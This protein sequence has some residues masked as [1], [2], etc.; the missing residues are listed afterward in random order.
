MIRP[1][2]CLAL[3]AFPLLPV[4]AAAQDRLP[5]ETRYTPEPFWY[6]GPGAAFAGPKGRMRIVT[7]GGISAA[8]NI[9]QYWT[10]E[11]AYRASMGRLAMRMPVEQ[12]DPLARK[13]AIAVVLARYPDRRV[14]GFLLEPIEEVGR[15]A[16]RTVVRPRS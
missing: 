7:G 13:E 14:N 9:N 4:S 16:P 15:S 6:Q 12:A 5:T 8:L 2:L 11:T 1:L 10:Y 3:A